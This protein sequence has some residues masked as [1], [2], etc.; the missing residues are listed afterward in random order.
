[1]QYSC[2]YFTDPAQQPRTGPARQEGPSRRQAVSEA[3]PEGARHRLRLGRA[4]ALSQS[5][6]R[7]R[8]AR[9]HALD[10]AAAGGARAGGRGGRVGPGQVRADGLSRRRPARSTGS[11]RS[12]CSSMSA[13]LS[14]GPSSARCRDLLADDGVMV[15]HTMGRMGKP[16]TTDPFMQKYIFPGGYIPALSEIAQGERARAA[17]HVRLA[18]RCGSIT[19]TRLMHWYERFKPQQAEV[20]R[21]YDERFYRLWLFYLAASPDDVQRRRHGRLPAPVS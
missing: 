8:R 16:G 11:S 18:R 1:M 2:G 12:A 5:R 10:G 17:D 4:G 9:G 13:R 19:S 21:L 14:T 15:L 7:R 20:V 6:R 3:R